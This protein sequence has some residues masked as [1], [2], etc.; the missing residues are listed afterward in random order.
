MTLWQAGLTALSV[1]AGAGNHQW[2]D[3]DWDRLERF[4]DIVISF[5][6]DEAGDKGAAEVMKRL[7]A[8]RCRRMKM[9]AKD[10]NQWLMDGATD[11]DFNDA[12]K[13]AK[14]NTMVMQSTTYFLAVTGRAKKHQTYCTP[15]AFAA[16]NTWTGQ[17]DQKEKD[18][19]ITLF[20]MI[21]TLR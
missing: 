9:G 5:D 14:T 8:D 19:T 13:N 1:N 3:S 18:L 11:Q 15:S 17:A 2:I 21:K 12:F 4:S 10:A 6:H 16:S 7:G 20:S